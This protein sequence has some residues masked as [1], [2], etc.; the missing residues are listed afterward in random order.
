MHNIVEFHENHPATKSKKHQILS[1]PPSRPYVLG[2][3]YRRALASPTS[4]ALGVARGLRLTDWQRGRPTAADIASQ[5]RK[6]TYSLA[7]AKTNLLVGSGVDEP[8]H[9]PDQMVR[10]AVP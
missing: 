8:G 1:V 5:V 2:D 9:A 4:Q 10:H 6:L 7:G 3:I